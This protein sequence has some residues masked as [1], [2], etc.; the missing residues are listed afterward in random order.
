ME[1]KE[2]KIITN[3]NIDENNSADKVLLEASN[4]IIEKIQ[5]RFANSYEIVSEEFKSPDKDWSR[6]IK[7]SRGNKVGSVIDLNWTKDMPTKLEID[8]T[9]SSKIGRILIYTIGISFLLLGAYMGMNDIEPLAFLPGYKLAAGLGG[10]IALIPAAILIFILQKM[11][12]T[13]KDNE[14]SNKL[15]QDIQKEIMG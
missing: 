6:E 10:L 7:V 13:K 9:K 1:L 11:I 8:V 4:K 15:V 5:E 2:E 14:E 12:I 3:L